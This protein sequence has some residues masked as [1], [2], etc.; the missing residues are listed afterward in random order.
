MRCPK[1]G[2]ISFDNQERCKKCKK[3]IGEILEEI[4]GTTYS[5]SSPVF[6]RV[7]L[8]ED[9][10]DVTGVSLV[11]EV[12]EELHEVYAEDTV[13]DLDEISIDMGEDEE[14]ISLEDED[15][16]IALSL[17]DLEATGEEEEIT[18]D[19]GE[20]ESAEEEEIS[21]TIDFGDID[22]S[23]LSPPMDE[24]FEEKKEVAF[25]L[26]PEPEVAAVSAP[27]KAEPS[28]AQLDDLGNLEDL[29]LDEIELTKS[30][31]PL[32]GRR[33][34]PSVKTGTALD[35]FD[36]DLGELFEEKETK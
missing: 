12:P 1:C 6:L 7:Q 34:A 22:I 4:Q 10:G 9:E 11:E 13:E 3:P 15:E 23:D 14:V 20:D 17:D 31:K 26:E 32:I 27:P 8:G 30:I 18:I 5:V 21:G 25:K 19:L 29:V 35:N 28:E 2:Y 24:S 16:E 36:I 33:N